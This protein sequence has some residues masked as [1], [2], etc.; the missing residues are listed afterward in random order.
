M[1]F[2]NVKNLHLPSEKRKINPTTVPPIKKNKVEQK[3]NFDYFV[4]N[5]I[6]DPLTFQE[7]DLKLE[8]VLMDLEQRHTKTRSILYII[9]PNVFRG[10]IIK[11]G[12]ALSNR[13]KAKAYI[14]RLNDYRSHYGNFD[15]NN[16]CK[17]CKVKYLLFGRRTVIINLEEAMKNHFSTKLQQNV[18]G[19]EWV[20]VSVQDLLKFIKDYI[21]QKNF[22]KSYAMLEEYK[23]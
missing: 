18:H 21:Q 14:S 15:K 20:K 3:K 7:V 12:R 2:Q 11:F 17:G 5:I 16:S 19:S 23:Q 22:D 13:E 9:E 8:S 4:N 10:R 1:P 6:I